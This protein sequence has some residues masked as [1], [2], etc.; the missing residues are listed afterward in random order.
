MKIKNIS[1][2]VKFFEKLNECSGQIEL[3]TE[4]GDVLNLRS[5]LCRYIAMTNVFTQ[6]KIGEMELRFSNDKDVKLIIDYL[7]CGD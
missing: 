4:D 5:K 1:D 2:P 7:V 6:A 3:I